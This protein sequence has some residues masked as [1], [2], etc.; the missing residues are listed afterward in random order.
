MNNLFHYIV[1]V[2]RNSD[3]IITTFVCFFQ[4]LWWLS[5]FLSGLV[6]R[7]LE[8]WK[9]YF[10]LNFPWACF[11]GPLYI[12]IQGSP[13]ITSSRCVDHNFGF[14]GLILSA[15]IDQ[16]SRITWICPLWIPWSVFLESPGYFC[17]VIPLTSL[18][19]S[20]AWL[21]AESYKGISYIYPLRMSL[22]RN[23]GLICKPV[24]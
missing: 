13:I 8:I 14:S 22:L 9:A 6:F 18:L 15:H 24:D 3:P 17:F 12:D 2:F 10:R 5:K 7:N 23:R 11:L 19:V 20:P 16:L 4:S 21:S 1:N